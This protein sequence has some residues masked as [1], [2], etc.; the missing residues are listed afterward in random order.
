MRPFGSISPRGFAIAAFLNLSVLAGPA[1]AAAVQNF[2]YTGSGDLQ[3]INAM[4]K[5]PDIAG[6]Q[7]VYN[8][9]DL[10]KNKGQY[11]FSRIEQDLRYLNGLN[12]KLFIQI[13]DR[14]FEPQA[15]NVPSYL[16]HDPVYGGGLVPQYDNPGENRPIGNGWV[17]QQWNP[18]VQQRYQQLLAALAKQFDGRVMGINLPETA[19]DLDMKH[20]KT[21]F[22][23]D[24]YFD[25]TL[26]NL[27]FARRAFRQSHVVQYVNFWPCEWNNDHQYMS[28]LFSFASQNRIG[29][30]GPDI[31]PWKKG[32]MKNAYPFFN[33]YKGKL[34]LVAMSVQEPTLTYTNPRTRKP[35][36]R[37]AFVDYAQD[38]LGANLIFWST[39]SPWLKEK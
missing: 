39:K 3:Q 13:Q 17:A 24:R 26:G 21:G 10:E 5:R 34:A 11:D 15:R 7:I 16:L 4:I 29:L 1:N 23:C 2:L 36:T 33:R 14:F 6:V 30:G 38:Y 28:R 9:K 18:A 35:F 25:A 12:R 8:W 32:Q 19:I 22:S 37:D 31:V 27:D 20:D